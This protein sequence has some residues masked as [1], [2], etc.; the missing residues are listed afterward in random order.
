M[1]LM[2]NKIESAHVVLSSI[3]DSTSYEYIKMLSKK[4]QTILHLLFEDYQIKWKYFC[5]NGKVFFVYQ[6]KVYEPKSIYNRGCSTTGET[7]GLKYIHSFMECSPANK[8]SGSGFI[9]GSKP[10]QAES[11]I[12]QSIKKLGLKNVKYPNTVIVKGPK[13]MM[14]MLARNF[15][16]YI[17]KS[18]SYVRSKVVDQDVI[19][20]WD[21]F[22]A[23]HVPTMFQETIEG[24][25]IRDHFAH[26][27]DH[28]V[29][30]HDND[31]LD[32]RYSVKEITLE[33]HSCPVEVSAFTLEIAKKEDNQL[34]GVDFILSGEKYYCLEANPTPGWTFF[35]IFNKEIATKIWSFS[36]V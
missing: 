19:K 14:K 4:S 30:I 12:I 23:F 22:E 9:N 18:I 2:N 25:N 29:E 34:M 26:G 3:E 1:D 27:Q 33:K 35:N 5:V 16:K 28:A 6:G 36:N 32:Y 13:S 17:I 7:G 31:Q 20:T 11:T 8:I 24:I 15:N 21:H 10:L